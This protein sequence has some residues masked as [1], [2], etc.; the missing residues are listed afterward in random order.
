MN[1]RPAAAGSVRSDGAGWW[2]PLV[3]IAFVGIPA[4]FGSLRVIGLVSGPQMM[5]ADPRMTASPVP[6]IV[7]IISAI[8]YA[9]LGAFQ[10]S[11]S[12][13]RRRPGWHRAAGRVLVVLGSA[14]AVTAMWMTLV[15][16]RQPGTGELAFLF[17]VA[18]SSGLA[19]SL[20]LGV[21]AIRHGD[22]LR[23]RAW[24]IRAYAL[25]LGAGTQVFT[26]GIG[27]AVFG[28]SQLTLDLSLGAAWVINLTVAEYVIR[29]PV[30]RWTH[31]PTE[32]ATARVG[33]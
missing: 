22:V 11:G 29:R 8:G 24:M 25:A 6:V 12:L 17:R 16:P 2:V 33:S 14:V 5:P 9:V 7:H 21:T 4:L 3:L 28:T 18:F 27:P 31:Q 15:Y 30:N 10:F 20:I 13:R 23:H 26:K 32:W 1:T 19:A